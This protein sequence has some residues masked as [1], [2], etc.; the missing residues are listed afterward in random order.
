M[1]VYL[2]PGNIDFYN[3]VNHSKF[4]IDK[5][6]LISHINDILFGEQRFICVSR[7][8]RFGKSMAANMLTAYY[9]KGCDSKE[10]FG[11]F[12]ISKSPSFEKHINKYNVI[13]VD[14][15]KFFDK[16]KSVDEMLQKFQTRIIK[17]LK[18][19]FEAD[20]EDNDLIYTLEEIYADTSEPF[21]FIIDEWDCVLRAE[22]VSESE[23]KTYLDFLCSLF[24]GQSY[25][26][27]AYMTGILP[28]KKYGVHSA[29][30][31]FTEVS[32][33]NARE[34][35]E[36]TGFT[37][38]EVREL[39]KEYD[40]PFEETK[41]WYDGYDLKGISIYNPR[42]V[43][44]SMTGHDYDNYWT[45]TE[46]YKALK[47]YIVLNFD[48]LKDKVTQMISGES[49]P[50]NTRTFQND[51][52]TFES[53]D[54]ILTLLI[55]LGY[56][57]YDFYNKTVRIPNNEIQQEF[58]NSIEQGGWEEVVR[59]IKRSDQLLKA[60]IDGDE[61]LVA[62]MIEESHLDNTSILKYNDENS[63]SCVITLAY[64]TARNNYSIYR[65]MPA[66]KGFADMVFIPRRNDSAPAMVV[67]LKYDKTAETAIDQIK[68]NKYTNALKE[69]KGD[70]LIVGIN[71]D[72]DSKAH[73]CKIEK[74]MK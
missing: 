64:Y 8:R 55:H 54:D 5:T 62:E 41:R 46:T 65:E 33:T 43:V 52:T 10:L 15:Q 42:S 47:D 58:I 7:P 44:M 23:Q 61:K 12:N 19:V 13:R 21:I 70:I 49:I 32:M 72:K 28:I 63:L 35:A 36:F 56:L 34:Y 18:K 16:K 50:V 40:M 69:Y 53:A 4:Y 67:E 11:G 57:T 9:G 2:N 45:Y 29:I 37:E 59:S 68:D 22:E 31:M 66:G 48:G 14:M 26:A 51:M 20:T 60:T 38:D 3:A 25:V 71:Y 27:L 39:C 74:L 1:G 6:N 30:N 24:K 73:E 17:D